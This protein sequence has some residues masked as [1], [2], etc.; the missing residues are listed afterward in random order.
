MARNHR[1]K[2]S[3]RDQRRQ[4]HDSLVGFKG[5]FGVFPFCRQRIE[6]EFA[7]NHHAAPLLNPRL[8]GEK[9]M[10]RPQ[11]SLRTLLIAVTAFA[12]LLARLHGGIG[13]RRTNTAT[14]KR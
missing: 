6:I 7:A 4:R 3:H 11:F 9:P 12:I 5:W 2:E 10:K 8:G 13:H 14:S 1:A